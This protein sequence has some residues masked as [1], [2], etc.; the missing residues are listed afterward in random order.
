M[1]NPHFLNTPQV[2]GTGSPAVRGSG[3]KEASFK[4][5]HLPVGFYA[6]TSHALT[7]KSANYGP[8]AKSGLP[9]ALFHQRAKN[10]LQYL[11]GEKSEE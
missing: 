9:P 2:V 11:G 1:C 10:I 3:L 7:Q 6:S 4:L 5:E 8:W